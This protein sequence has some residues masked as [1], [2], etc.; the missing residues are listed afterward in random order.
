[1]L[2]LLD[3]LELDRVHLG[4]L[5]L[6]GMVAMW[7]AATAPDRVDR[8]ALLCTSARPGQPEAWRQRAAAVRAAGTGAVAD[9]VLGRWFTAD[10]MRRR[11]DVVAWARAMLTGTAADAYAECCEV[12]ATLDLEPLLPR[13]TAPTLVVAGA[14]DPA[15]PLPHTERI[16]AGITGSRLAVVDA[17]HLASAEQ[18]D[19]VTEL[20]I[21]FYDRG[22][23]SP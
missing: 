12:V 18:P 21:G 10:F 16:L 7:L 13:I 22:G 2:A 5:S 1:V 9:A 19:I 23:S 17:A 20:L 14:V 8:L 4:G 3:R 11:P 15:F 6:G